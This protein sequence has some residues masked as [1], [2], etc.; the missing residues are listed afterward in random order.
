MLL[1]HKISSIAI[2]GTTLMMPALAF[3]TRADHAVIM[4]A[5]TGT[6]LFEKD[7][8][9]PMTPASMTKIMTAYLVFERLSD[10]RLSPDDQFTVSEDAWRRGGWASGGSTMG[11]KIGETVRVEDL[12]HGMLVQSGNDA[13][14]VLAEGISGTEAAF[15]VEM[16]ERA[17]DLGLSSAHFT[18]ATGLYDDVHV[19]SALDLA[20]LAQLTIEKFPELYTIYA[21]AGFEWNG[22]YQPNRNPLMQRFKGTDGLKTGHLEASG[23]GLVGSALVDGERRIIVVNGL[24]N[25][26]AR[27]EESER[28]MRAAFREFDVVK[29]FSAGKEI[30]AVPVWLGKQGSV[31]LALADDLSFGFESSTKRDLK[32]QIFVDENITAPVKA[33]DVLGYLTVTGANGIDIKRDIVASSDVA[34]MGLLET[35]L[36]GFTRLF[37]KAPEPEEATTPDS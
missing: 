5:E 9:A 4:D 1:I 10:G 32:A 20:K 16:T 22:I 19:I 18:N 12:L 34:K 15:A 2:L 6:V 13:C 23:Y 33:G 27:A 21:G 28:V 25:E 30:A 31:G 24:E 29:P 17:Q 35:A 3:E 14:I 8:R 11:L 36:E 37:D 7:A 26:L